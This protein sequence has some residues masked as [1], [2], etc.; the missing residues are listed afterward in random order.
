MLFNYKVLTPEGSESKGQIDAASVDAAISSLQR[1]GFVVVSV[2]RNFH[3]LTRFP[4]K[5]L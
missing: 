5:M 1:R 2:K 4:E 3:S